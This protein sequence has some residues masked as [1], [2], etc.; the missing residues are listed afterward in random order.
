MGK[1]THVQSKDGTTATKI[2]ALT[3]PKKDKRRDGR[4]EH[5]CA[6]ADFVDHPLTPTKRTPP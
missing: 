5:H 6:R 4:N 1:D 3:H 2:I